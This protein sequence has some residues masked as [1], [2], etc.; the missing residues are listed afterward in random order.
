M[1]KI[2]IL[3]AAMILALGISV[4]RA[5]ALGQTTG[6]AGV[7]CK[8]GVCEFV[9][10]GGGERTALA[11]QANPYNNAVPD[12]E[13]QWESDVKQLGPHDT[14]VASQSDP[15]V[16]VVFSVNS[17]VKN[18]KVLSLEFKD[19][20]NGKPVFQVKELFTKDV[21]RPERQLLVK[22]TFFGSIPNNGFSYTDGNGKTRYYSVSQSG[23]DGSLLFSEF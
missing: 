5:Q 6:A 2:S 10:A 19:F 22:Y 13:G 12:I 7:R 9:P 23:M 15:Q 3:A 14:F 1:K 21:L 4:C 20:A 8:D 18:F 17:P 16:G 11:A